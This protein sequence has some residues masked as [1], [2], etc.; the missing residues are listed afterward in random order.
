[1]EVALMEEDENSEESVA[2]AFWLIAIALA[3][4]WNAQE[5]QTYIEWWAVDTLNTLTK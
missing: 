4:Q 3:Y 5:Y 2:Q 1:M